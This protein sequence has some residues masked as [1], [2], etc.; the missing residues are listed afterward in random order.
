MQD[1][2]DARPGEMPDQIP[3]VGELSDITGLC[4]HEYQPFAWLAGYCMLT[5]T[6]KCPLAEIVQLMQEGR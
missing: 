3:E 4:M 2:I 6:M 1:V 5:T